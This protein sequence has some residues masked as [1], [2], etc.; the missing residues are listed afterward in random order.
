M[1][2]KVCSWV[3]ERY[4]HNKGL[5]DSLRHRDWVTEEGIRRDEWPAMGAGL[6]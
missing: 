3:R 2:E 6:S 4:L 5:D 1:E